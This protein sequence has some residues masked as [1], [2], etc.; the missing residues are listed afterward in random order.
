MPYVIMPRRDG[1]GFVTPG[2]AG[3]P[4]S[5]YDLVHLTAGK[6]F[7]ADRT[8]SPT[9]PAYGMALSDIPLNYKAKILLYGLV[10]N[11]DWAWEDGAIYPSETPGLLTQEPPTWPGWAQSV[12]VSYGADYMLFAPMWIKQLDVSPVMTQAPV[13]K[14]KVKNLYVE[15]I[16]GDSKLIYEWDDEEPQ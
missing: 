16:G 15:V 7:K 2:I 11:L 5:K 14:F 8:T 1:D 12:G 4:L 9:L 6:W 10:S 3:E 13:G